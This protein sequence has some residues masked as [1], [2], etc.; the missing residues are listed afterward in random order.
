MTTPGWVR[1]RKMSR[2]A[3]DTMKKLT[4]LSAM[5]AVEM[6]IDCLPT[7]LSEAWQDELITHG[8]GER[9]PDGSVTLNSLGHE[10]R[11]KIMASRP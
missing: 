4:N 9:R 10:Y 2:H 8:V 7:G 11:A 6:W 1:L 5:L 3:R